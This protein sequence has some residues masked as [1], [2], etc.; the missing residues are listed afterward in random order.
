MPN[1]RKSVPGE[2]IA[3]ARHLYEHTLVPTKDIAALLG[4]SRRTL[5]TR[6]AE[7][8]WTRRQQ[9]GLELTRLKRG[10]DGR[11]RV[12]RK[13]RPRKGAGSVPQSPP[14]R[15]AL[16]ER[17][18]AVAEREIAA[19]EQIIETLG[20]ADPGETEGAARTLA[21]LAR[22]LRELVQLDVPAA[23]TEPT[24]DEPIPRDLA[25]LRRSLARKL[26]A[27]AAE[28]ADPLPGQT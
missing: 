6:A 4:F 8:G 9:G 11:A 18:Q 26:E 10:K 16:A 2:K 13:T 22:T 27:L 5:Q 19:V 3:E 21:S 12:A 1:T 28:E 24:H 23:S 17:I 25:E 15:L 7:W 14:E 20:G